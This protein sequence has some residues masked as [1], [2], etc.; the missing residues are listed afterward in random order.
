MRPLVDLLPEELVV[1][2][3]TD[4]EP[5]AEGDSPKRWWG[6]TGEGLVPRMTVAEWTTLKAAGTYCRSCGVQD[7]L[8]AWGRWHV[9]Q[10][11]NTCLKNRGAVETAKRSARGLDTEPEAPLRPARRTFYDAD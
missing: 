1:V 4:D 9:P 10:H 2:E 8:D 11:R 3:I 7:D 5:L 6:R